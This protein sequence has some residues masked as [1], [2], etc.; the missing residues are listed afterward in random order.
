MKAALFIAVLLV[1]ACAE[2]VNFDCSNGDSVLAMNNPS[3]TK[4]MKVIEVVFKKGT[5]ATNIAFL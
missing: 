2:T 5:C 1:L 4:G 3:I